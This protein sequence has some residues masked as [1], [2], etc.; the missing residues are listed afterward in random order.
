LYHPENKNKIPTS[1]DKVMSNP[2]TVLLFVFNGVDI[3]KVESEMRNKI[4]S[5]TNCDDMNIFG[6]K[7]LCIWCD[8][9]GLI[10]WNQSQKLEQTEQKLEQTEQKL[11]QTEQSLNETESEIIQL[12]KRV[13]ELEQ[14]L[15]PK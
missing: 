15:Q 6:H 14:Q 9:S 12:K 5:K 13:A 11:E 8:S 7:V 2:Q 10:M 1:L 3:S 4:K